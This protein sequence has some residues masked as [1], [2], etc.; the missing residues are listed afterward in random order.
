M[1]VVWLFSSRFACAAD[2]LDDLIALINGSVSV[3]YI[4]VALPS[5]M[6]TI[7]GQVQDGAWVYYEGSLQGHT[8]WMR[9][10][11]NSLPGSGPCLPGTMVGK[12]LE[13]F[14][15]FEP[16]SRDYDTHIAVSPIESTGREPPEIIALATL[17][18]V[19]CACGFG[20]PIVPGS[21]VVNPDHSFRAIAA[22]NG[23]KMT[24]RFILTKDDR[25]EGCKIAISTAP[26]LR[27]IIHYEYGLSGNASNI[28][29]RSIVSLFRGD[30]LISQREF[31]VLACEL[32][33]LSLP[34][35]G[36]TPQSVSPIID[37]LI[38]PN[39]FYNT[40][41]FSNG[42]ASQVSHRNGIKLLRDASEVIVALRRYRL[43]VCLGL[44]VL[45]APLLLL[46]L[47]RR[48]RARGRDIRA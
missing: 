4:K 32:G 44:S 29:V 26:D 15:H 17:K 16:S 9:N 13:N 28:P 14:W 46:W 24:G 22:S 10:C 25:A 31:R 12:S 34:E 48:F 7:E 8:F 33:A 36:F 11:T 5:E 20:M 45:L 43:R 1:S 6:F 41:M 19:N 47:V 42:T 39:K 38:R 40:V 37:E 27:R 30:T 18:N 21:L 2:R 23:G 3:Q 35:T